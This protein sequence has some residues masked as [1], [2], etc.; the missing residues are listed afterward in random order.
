MGKEMEPFNLK[1]EREQGHF[2]AETGSFVWRDKGGDGNEAGDEWLQA[3]NESEAGMEEA[4]GQ[5]A[6]AQRR[7]LWSK[8]G[9]PGRGGRL[10]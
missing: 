9:A 5:A 3:M 8:R 10:P 7:Q 1:E 6:A 4:I 2:D